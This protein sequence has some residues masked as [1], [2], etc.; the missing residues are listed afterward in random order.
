VRIGASSEVFVNLRSTLV[1]VCSS[2]CHM[3][4]SDDLGHQ[5]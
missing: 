5:G 2:G 3:T 1:E 4:G